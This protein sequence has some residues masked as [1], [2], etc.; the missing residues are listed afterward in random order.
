M[1]Q[2]IDGR[3]LFRGYIMHADL[4]VTRGRRQQVEL[5]MPVQV[6]GA[7]MRV[8]AACPKYKPGHFRTRWQTDISM[9]VTDWIDSLL[10]KI[11]LDLKFFLIIQLVKK[12]MFTLSSASCLNVETAVW[13]WFRKS[14]SL[15]NPSWPPLSRSVP[16]FGW[17]FILFMVLSWYLIWISGFGFINSDSVTISLYNSPLEPHDTTKLSSSL[18]QLISCRTNL[19]SLMIRF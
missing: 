5:R 16:S 6:H 13:L 3:I 15:I 12:Q 18:D 11:N 1:G 8:Q 10:P 14:M 17:K 7:Q 9:T 19:S 2:I 4:S